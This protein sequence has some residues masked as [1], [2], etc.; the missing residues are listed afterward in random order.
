M[1]ETLSL[2]AADEPPAAEV[3]NPGS[4]S[5]LLLVSDHAGRS[6]PRR[7]GDLGVAAAEMDR[8]IA[9]DIGIAPVGVTLGERL[10][11]TLIAQRY[12]RLVI[13]CNRAP[14]HPTS[15][16][17]VSDGT[18]VPGNVDLSAGD[19]AARVREVFD[20]YHAAIAAELDRRGAAPCAVIALHSFTPV[21][22]GVSRPWEA[23]VLY[24]RDPGFSLAVGRL[25]R[26]AGLAVGD[27]EPYRLEESWD[28]TVP[29]HAL[30]RGLPYLE[31]EIRQD[32]IGDADGQ[33]RWADLLAEVL[34]AAWIEHAGARRRT[35]RA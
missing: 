10:G 35:D 20:P 23:G 27:N 3:R 30:R 12:S 15:I 31:L 5:P 1:A 24:D 19:A 14:G 18:V 33:R 13:D 28:Y 6:V 7:L 21:F 29:V 25:L 17:P 16:P 26:E 34:P 11:A 9:Y 32:L 8:H 22:G 4:A 2:L